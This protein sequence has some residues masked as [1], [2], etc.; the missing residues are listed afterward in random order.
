M[1]DNEIGSNTFTYSFGKA[2]DYTF[3]VIACDPADDKPHVAPEK[4]QFTVTIKYVVDQ[5]AYSY[6]KPITEQVAYC[7]CNKCGADVTGDENG[8]VREYDP[9]HYDMYMV[10]YHYQFEGCSTAWHTA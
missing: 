9:E 10:F 4:A 2:G 7:C 6:E 1:L 8:K 3:A 5:E